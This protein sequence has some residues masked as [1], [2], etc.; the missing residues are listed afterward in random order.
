MFCL[1]VCFHNSKTTWP[2]LTKILC[3]LF[4]AV[5]WFSSD[6]VAIYYVLL[7]LQMTSSFHTMGPMG[8]WTRCCV[9]TRWQCQLM[10]LLAGY[11]LLQHTGSLSLRAGLLGQLGTSAGPVVG[12]PAVGLACCWGRWC[13][14]CHVL[15]ASSE[16]HAGVKSALY[17]FIVSHVTTLF[18]FPSWNNK[19]IKYARF[20]LC[21][22]ITC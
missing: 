21:H 12:C 4:V 8:R 16:L 17:D 15:H 3:M 14:F 6:S 5:A 2:N 19:I 13:A 18:L 7:V 22:L 10:W 11:G 9:E 1:S 20:V